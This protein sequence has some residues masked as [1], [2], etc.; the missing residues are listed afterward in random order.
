MFSLSVRI[1][2]HLF[3]RKNFQNYRKNWVIMKYLWHLLCR[4]KARWGCEALSFFR[5][6]RC[7]S[8]LFLPCPIS[9]L[10][11]LFSPRTTRRSPPGAHPIARLKKL[12]SSFCLWLWCLIPLSSTIFDIS[13]CVC[14]PC[15]KHYQYSGQKLHFI[16][17]A[18]KNF[19]SVTFRPEGHQET[20]DRRR[21][22]R[23]IGAA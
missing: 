2:Y 20:K 17:S 13:K 19:R 18:T 9:H 5:A 21:V 6:F 11:S 1:L 7:T 4:C 15:F 23:T 10:S 8:L 22:L 3:V 14:V 12:V 16:S